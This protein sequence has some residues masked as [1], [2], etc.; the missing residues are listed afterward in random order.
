MF[1]PPYV[2]ENTPTLMYWNFIRSP[3]QTILSGFDYHKKCKETWTRVALHETSIIGNMSFSPLFF[4][5]N[6]PR[7]IFIREAFF[8]TFEL[9]KMHKVKKKNFFLGGA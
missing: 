7:G 1:F 5:I 3:L 6:K 8:A 2:R 9:F 4:S